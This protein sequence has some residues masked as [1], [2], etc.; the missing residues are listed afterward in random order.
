MGSLK[1]LTK[2]ENSHGELYSF[3]HKKWWLYDQLEFR[4]PLAESSYLLMITTESHLGVLVRN[5]T[6]MK[7]AVWHFSGT[8]LNMLA[9]LSHIKLKN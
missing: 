6:L 7:G 3:V 5:S 9:I 8:A 2:F 4:L 1:G